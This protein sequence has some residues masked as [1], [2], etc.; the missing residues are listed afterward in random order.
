MHR[1]IRVLI[2]AVLGAAASVVSGQTVYFVNASAPPGG[3]GLSWATAFQHPQQGLDAFPVGSAEIW[4]AAGT[5]YPTTRISPPDPR[6]A[7]FVMRNRRSLYGGFAGNETSRVQRDPAANPTIFSGDIGELED[8]SDNAF[9]VVYA[10]GDD[11]TTIL[12]GVIV[13]DGD[14]GATIQVG[15]GLWGDGTS[16]QIRNCIFEDNRA[17]YQG[18]AVYFRGSGNPVVAD[19][20]FRDNIAADWGG[21]VSCK[22]AR[23]LFIRC[24]FQDNVGGPG[25]GALRLDGGNFEL[26]DCAFIGNEALVGAG[27]STDR[28]RHLVMSGCTF[29]RNIGWAGNAAASLH[30]FQQSTIEYC[31][32]V[33]NVALAGDGGAL[34][35]DAEEPVWIQNCTF[36][37]NEAARDGGAI[38]GRLSGGGIFG[39]L[40][41]DNTAGGSGGGIYI[42][43]WAA[44]PILACTFYG[45]SAGALGG[46]CFNA[47]PRFD[48]QSLDCI[49]WANTDSTGSGEDAQLAGAYGQPFANSCTIQGWSGSWS[50]SYNNGFDPLFVDATSGDFALSPGSPCIDSGDSN[51]LP[52][53]PLIDARRQPRYVDDPATPD[54]GFGPPPLIDR[55][56]IEFQATA[57][58]LVLSVSG[59]CPQGSAMLITCAG[60]TPHSQVA[61]LF[62]ASAGETYI[63][64]GYPCQ[65]IMLG[66]SDQRLTVVL[67]ERSD[68]QGSLARLIF[69]PREACIGS[70][71]ALD[72]RYCRTSNVVPLD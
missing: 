19:T 35:V 28:V 8:P 11:H 59:S 31:T 60:A 23:A 45:N 2:L 72:L 53:E 10:V 36:E 38:Y 47:G 5:Y 26:V 55:G 7:T 54:T 66:L 67:A 69:V 29:E 27:L 1:A 18:A 15:A 24:T 20:L 21:A 61:I 6:T 57:R 22:S 3:D 56:A 63:P 14:A 4:V 25:G 16:M 48:A 49:Y 46:G 70:L 39:C 17:Q 64:Q 51:T 33:E 44:S 40:I 71:Q 68:D 13:R 37:R 42:N 12:D 62:A 9:H 32:F 30:L 43:P 52:P 50:G 34:T 41:V 58:P 65:G